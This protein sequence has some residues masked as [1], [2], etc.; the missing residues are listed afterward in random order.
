MANEKMQVKTVSEVVEVPVEAP[1][2]NSSL[3]ALTVIYL[4]A[5]INAAAAMFGF[6][7]NIQANEDKIYEGFS[8]IFTAGSFIVGVWKN[9]N[10]TKQ[11]R[12]KAAAAEQ[13]RVAGK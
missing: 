12:I 4:I 11:A 7:L 13:V 3:V 9:H 8:I 1:K 5:I 2:V 10:F 6:D